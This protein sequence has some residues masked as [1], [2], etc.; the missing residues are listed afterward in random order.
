MRTRLVRDTR[1]VRI[2]VVRGGF[3]HKAGVFTGQLSNGPGK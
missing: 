2:Y 3:G 1:N